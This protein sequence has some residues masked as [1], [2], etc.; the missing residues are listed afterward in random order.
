MA[1]YIKPSAINTYL[2]GVVYRLRPYYPEITHLRLDPHVKNVL[3]GLQRRHGSNIHR[4]QPITFHQLNNLFTSYTNKSYDDLLFLTM[5]S[6]GFFRLLRLGEL[7]DPNDN[8]L[9]NHRKTIRRMSS[10][11]QGNTARFLLPASK[12]DHF[13]AGNEVIVKHNDH[14]NDP[15][16]ALQDYLSNRDRHFPT[17]EWLWLTSHGEPPTRR[18]FLARFHLHFDNR[19]GRH[20]LRAGGAT[21][22]TQQHVPFHII[23]AIGRWSSEA[24]L[25]YIR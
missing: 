4:K 12:T 20:S 1:K 17:N 3:R 14:H 25:I 6:V 16:T 24:F 11:L 10:T 15:V 19:Y 21:L 13:Y 7:T 8:C 18:W 23:Q 22:L 2:S 5:I 9:I